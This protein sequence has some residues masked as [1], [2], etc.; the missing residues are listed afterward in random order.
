MSVDELISTGRVADALA[1]AIEA[2][3]SAPADPR[4]RTL[5]AQLFEVTGQW[6]RSAQQWNAVADMDPGSA[7][8]AATCAA[9]AKIEVQRR[10]VFAGTALPVVFG[11]PEP[12]VALL[13]QA[14]RHASSGRFSAARQAAD[15]ALAQAPASAGSLNG[16]RFEW[17]ADGDCRLGPMIEAVVGGRYVWIP[18]SRIRAMTSAPPGSLRDL[19]WAPF[20]FTWSNGGTAAGYVPVRY[21][22]T[23]GSADGALLLAR[24][25]EWSEPSAGWFQGMGQRMLCTDSG[26]CALLDLRSLDLDSAG[27]P[28]PPAAHG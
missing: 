16:G 14:L 15:E 9:L 20:S 22:G 7:L 17:V 8:L 24:R 2:V 18:F 19:V 6:D 10:A 27:T 5:L 12:W 3:R 21:P 26:D 1:S 13:L 23:E 28:A 25:T 11:E 4:P